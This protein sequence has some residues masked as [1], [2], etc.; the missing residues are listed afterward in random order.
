[1]PTS[2]NGWPVL[3]PTSTQLVSM[4]VPGTT[5]RIRM[6]ADVIP[7][8]LALAS[9][10]S[11]SIDAIDQGTLDDWG[12]AYRQS[13]MSSAWSDHSSG[14]ALDLN[15]S[16]EGRQ[17][18]GPLAWWKSA[19]HYVL[20]TR[21]K[22]KYGVVIWGGSKAL[23][24]DYQYE[25][26]WDWMHWA[27]RPGTTLAQVQAKIKELGI[28]P[29]G[30]TI[31]TGGGQGT[32]VIPPPVKPPVVVPP[33]PPVVNPPAKPV[34]DLSMLQSAAVRDPKAAQGHTTYAHGVFIVEQALVKERLLDP[35]YAKD[36]S[37]GSLTV[38]AYAAWQRKLGYKGKSAN[39][40]PGLASLTALGKKYGFTVVA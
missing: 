1:M 23:G 31:P 15:A 21:L 5:R 39:G 25:K 38:A 4:T 2:I 11:H 14:T 19:Q 9:E 24:G 3:E 12:Y 33:K 17:G 26:N 34:V 16:T 35:K 6:R 8:F 27:I 29:D 18:T 7:L 10:Y 30:T 36:G 32:G 20:A 13:R 22:A 40:I 37:Y 28:Q